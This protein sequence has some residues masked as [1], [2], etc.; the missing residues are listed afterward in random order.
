MLVMTGYW[1]TGLWTHEVTRYY[2]LALPSIVGAV[3]LGRAVNQRLEAGS[4]LRYVHA[5]LVLIG[6]VLLLQAFTGSG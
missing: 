4:F 5:G 6:V 1:L 2:L 3:L